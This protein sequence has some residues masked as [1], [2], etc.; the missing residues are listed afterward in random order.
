MKIYQTLLLLLFFFTTGLLNAQDFMM[1]AWYWDYPKPANPTGDAATEPTWAKTL[2][3]QAADLSAA[4]FT[5]LWLPPASRASFGA[6]SNGYDPQ[7]L[8]DLGEFGQGSTGFGWRSDFDNL[9]NTMNANNIEAVA[10]VVYN[11]RDGGDWENNPAV[12]DYILSYPNR[13]DCGGQTP[14]PVNGKVRYVLPLGGS[15]LNGAGDY[16]IKFS[17]SS[18]NT[19]FNNREYKIYAQT[20]VVG[21]QN[22]AALDENE[23]NGGGDCGEAFRALPLGIDMEAIQEV[24]GLCNTDE[25]EI[26]ISA[27]DF[28]AAGDFIEIYIEQR[29]GDGTGIDIRPYGLWSDARTLDI[30]DELNVQTRTDFSNM[31]SGQGAMGYA[32]FQP[33]GVPNSGDYSTCMSG[34]LDFPFFFF[35]IEHA[36]PATVTAYQDWTKWLWN[37][38]GFRGFRM[39]AVKHFET[40]TVS[41]IVNDLVA[42]GMSP[43]MMVGEHFTVDAGTLKGWVDAVQDSLSAAAASAVNI[44]VF[45]FDLRQGLKDACDV[46][47]HDVRNVFNRGIVN[48]AGASGFNAVTFVNNH[49]Y[50]EEEQPVQNDPLLAYAY[51]LTNNAVGL[52]NIFYPDYFGVTIPHAPTN[53]LKGEIDRLIQAHKLHIAGSTGIEYLNRFGTT[54]SSNYIQGFAGA[55]GTASTSL[56]YQMSGAG[57]P[58]GDNVVVAINF[59]GETLKVDHEINTNFP[60]AP[61]SQ[62]EIFTDI[63]GNSPF[64]VAM[65]NSDNQIYMEVPPRSYSI[66]VQGAQ[67]VLPAELI[68]FEVKIKKNDVYLNWESESEENLATYVVERS[69]PDSQWRAVAEL[70]AKNIAT[71]AAYETVDTGVPTNTDLLYRLKMIDTDGTFS[72]SEVRKVRVEDRSTGFRVYPNPNSGIFQV[73]INSNEHSGPVITIQDLLGRKINVR[74]VEVQ[75]GQSDL[76]FDFSDLKKG[77]YFLQITDGQKVLGTERILI[78]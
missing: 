70:A 75:S 33:A 45:D 74:K 53:N 60:G 71:G 30:I 38:A 10:D 9:I 37:D 28:N 44:R 19:G 78:Q 67:S 2:E 64:P 43:S 13:G 47:G 18:E 14:Y 54:R 42:N 65:V 23:P 7:D 57:T 41:A 4:G 77:V 56:I 27:S 58:N 15:S 16:Y 46:F 8:Y 50:R 12:Q 29:N 55:N 34:D 25:Y 39:D 5:H 24:G 26:S 49:D 48:A 32:N 6:G 36:N 52:P 40:S 73:L 68:D 69:T 76:Q 1:Q 35:D 59:S 66:W 11:H 62:G 21:F 61:V 20:S 3:S 63:L 51:I 17:S 22:A 31:P 72:Y